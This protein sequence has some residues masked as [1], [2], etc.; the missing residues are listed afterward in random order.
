MLIVEEEVRVLD[1]RVVLVAVVDEML[2]SVEVDLSA[3]S[4]SG[5]SGAI[6]NERFQSCRKADSE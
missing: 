6:F 3:G 4:L 2:G 5:R 1:S